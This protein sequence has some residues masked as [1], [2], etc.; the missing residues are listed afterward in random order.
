MLEPMST[1]FLCFQA[2]D[3]PGSLAV[4]TLGLTLPD[5]DIGECG[6]VLEDEHGV[7]LARLGLTLTDGC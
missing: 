6:T 5:D 1:L 2:G 4:D 7:L 3:L